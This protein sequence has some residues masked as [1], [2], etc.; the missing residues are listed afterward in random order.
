MGYSSNRLND[1][2][3]DRFI[4]QYLDLF[5]KITGMSVGIV[6]NPYST[7]RNDWIFDSVDES[8]ECIRCI[9]KQLEQVIPLNKNIVFNCREGYD[10]TI[11]P[12]LVGNQLVGSIYCCNYYNAENCVKS[13]LKKGATREVSSEEKAVILDFLEN[14]AIYLS[15]SIQ[16]KIDSNRDK[17]KKKFIELI[18]Y[19]VDYYSNPEDV[20]T[21]ICHEIC[22]LYDI[23]TAKVIEFDLASNRLRLI[24]QFVDTSKSDMREFFGIKKY[25]YEI[26]NFWLPIIKK[27]I[28]NAEPKNYDLTDDTFLPKNLVEFYKDINIR[29]NL[30]VTID[31]TSTKKRSL[32]LFSNKPASYWDGELKYLKLIA[33]KIASLLKN[34]EIKNKLEETQSSISTL[35]ENSDNKTKEEI[36]TDLQNLLASLSVE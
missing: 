19:G 25:G 32:C 15:D 5:Q 16:M 22:R 36:K 11:V 4:R 31:S 6:G 1:K 29:S 27:E 23:P 14:L 9:K 3:D 26:M 8:D 33:K 20:L 18:T 30:G 28:P 13:N 10:T 2:F 24:K 35:V 7:I 34:I 21:I 12:V 17:I